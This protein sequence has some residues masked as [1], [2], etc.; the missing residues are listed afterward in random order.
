MKYFIYLTLAVLFWSGNFVFGRMVSSEIAAIELS[1]FRWF[2]VFLILLPYL[3]YRSKHIMKFFKKDYLILMIFGIIGVAGFNTFLYL[4]LKT[5]TATNALLI[6][7]SIPIMIIVLSAFILKTTITKIQGLGIILSTLGVIFLILKG[8]IENII[9]LH[10]THGDLWILFACVNWAL[11]TVLLKYKPKELNALDFLSI[12]VFIGIIVLSI[13]YFYAGY[14][15]DL[16]VFE[17]DKVL[18]SL[19]YMVVFPSL[20]SFYFWNTAIVEI[21]ASRAG[22]F[23]HLMPIFGAI[24]AFIFLGE[25]LEMYHVFGILF[26]ALGIYLSIFLKKV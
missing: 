23:T 24:L 13:V 21:G 20:L 3:I 4:G 12:T 14:S 7:S 11:Y 19:I 1:F 15:F 18:Y 6:N 8:S 26:I 5:T 17:N 9:N 16:A 10:F 2:F 22:Q 25:R